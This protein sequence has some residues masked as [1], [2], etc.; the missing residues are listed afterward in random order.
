MREV[1]LADKVFLY[2]DTRNLRIRT[3][4]KEDLS[5]GDLQSSVRL[6]LEEFPE[7]AVRV[8]R[9]EGRF[10][11]EP[12]TSEVAFY[13]DDDT[14]YRLGSRE[15]GGYPFLFR[16]EKRSFIFSMHHSLTDFYGMWM[17]LQTV[18]YHYG[19]KCGY[20]VEKIQI[21]DAHMD[22]TERFDP[23]RKFG[24]MVKV[25]E[26]KA[27][28]KETPEKEAFRIPE[29]CSESVFCQYEYRITVSAKE[30]LALTQKW[31]TSFV[32]AMTVIF[33][34]ALMHLYG[35]DARPVVSKVSADMRRAFHSFSRVN[36]SE[37]VV[38]SYGEEDRT[39][40]PKEVCRTLRE[41]VQ[42]QTTCAAWQEKMAA[43]ERFVEAKEK[44]AALPPASLPNLTY[45]LIYPGK[46][47]L[48]EAY[49]AWVESFRL[50]ALVP[51]DTVRFTVITCRDDM[52]IGIAQR[53][54]NDK[55]CEAVKEEFCR[56]GFSP[57]SE[58]IGKIRGDYY[59]P[60]E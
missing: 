41:S 42:A 47:D 13:P 15:T 57:L 30:F 14:A 1:G 53:F 35:E 59:T 20:P 11:Y 55:I 29:V 43:A 23:Y 38:L 60:E 8:I 17:F 39:L 50:E 31:Q 37:A 25:N 58:K 45:A 9:K 46:M 28:E 19:K 51:V 52:V 32:P 6:A 36:F 5:I 40:P 44:G 49:H 27:P 16:Y 2:K 3:I 34:N 56:F 10:F 4:L 24:N 48:P 18:L 12:N 54:S 22:D 21:P 7:Y 33:G 26:K